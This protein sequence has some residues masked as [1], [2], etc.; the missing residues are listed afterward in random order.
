MKRHIKYIVVHS[1]ATFDPKVSQYYGDFH[2]VV[3]R[4]GEIKRIHPETTIVTN[5]VAADNE[6]IHIAYAGG[7]N[8]AGNLG[9]TRTPVQEEALYNKLIALTVKYPS[10][11]IVGHNEFEAASGCPGFNIKDWL[12]AYE[13]EIAVA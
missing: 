5:V 9:D 2:Y 4:S 13:P 3:E 8:K 10:A 1:T 11:R 7:R 12:K 6:A